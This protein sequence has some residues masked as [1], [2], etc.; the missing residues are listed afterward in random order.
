VETFF[1]KGR[2]SVLSSVTLIIRSPKMFRPTCAALVALAALFTVTSPALA[3]YRAING[4]WVQDL[5]KGEFLVK[6]EGR[7]SET[8]FW[9]AAGNY[10]E[11]VLGASGKTRLY[12]V[13]PPPRKRGQG[14][15]FT[16]DAAK[17]GGATGI[18]SFGSGSAKDSLSVGHVTGNFCHFPRPLYFY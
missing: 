13:T 7:V 18:S 6:Y 1:R 12:R 5:G 10:A 14:I 3:D 17:S 2:G 16:L 8:D 4:M 9:C 11:R 15:I